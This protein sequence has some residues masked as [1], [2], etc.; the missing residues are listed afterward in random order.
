[1]VTD[2]IKLSFLLATI[3]LA[4]IS[5]TDWQYDYMPLPDSGTYRI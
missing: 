5:T 3:S 1:M 2:E 4:T